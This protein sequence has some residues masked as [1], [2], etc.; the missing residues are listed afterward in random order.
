MVDFDKTRDQ[1]RRAYSPISTR[2]LQVWSQDWKY[3]VST[4][5]YV[6][7][8]KL[9]DGGLLN[10]MEMRSIL[11]IDG[12]NLSMV[13]AD[14]E[15]VWTNEVAKGLRAVHCFRETTSGVVFYFAALTSTNN[16]ITGVLYV[17]RKD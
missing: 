12:L 4:I 11:N 10:M 15:R 5:P 3:G 2:E 1:W 17:S 8:T 6:R 7:L 16:Y 14:V 13:K 9:A